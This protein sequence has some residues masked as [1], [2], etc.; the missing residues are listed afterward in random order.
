MEYFKIEYF[1]FKVGRQIVQLL[2]L[3]T[4][5]TWKRARVSIQTLK[6][7]D[8]TCLKQIVPD[9]RLFI[10]MKYISATWIGSK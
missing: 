10:A 2:L 3:C 1:Q 8:V 6:H 5:M 9:S 7:I 4:I